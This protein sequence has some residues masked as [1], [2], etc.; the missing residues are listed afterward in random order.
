MPDNNSL[1]VRFFLS[2]PA[3]HALSQEATFDGTGAESTSVRAGMG[4]SDVSTPWSTRE[5]DV[6]SANQ[7]IIAVVVGRCGHC[8]GQDI[9]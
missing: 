6:S 7:R 4:L 5:G 9:G 3:S 2:D 8:Q 1:D